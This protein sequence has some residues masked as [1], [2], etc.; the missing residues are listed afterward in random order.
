MRCALFVTVALCSLPTTLAYAQ[1]KLVLPDGT[2]IPVTDTFSSIEIREHTDSRLVILG[3]S[4]RNAMVI[5]VL[6]DVYRRQDFDAAA[7]LR[8]LLSAPMLSL[9]PSDP[10]RGLVVFESGGETVFGQVLWLSREDL[11]GPVHFLLMGESPD[12]ELAESDFR[13][14][15]GQ[16]EINVQ[17]SEL[18]NHPSRLLVA[19][20]L[21][22][23]VA[24]LLFLW[25]AFGR[26]AQVSAFSDDFI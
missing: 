3:H 11:A 18:A 16:M 25:R 2:S 10:N 24:N 26:Y 6:D 4:E 13:R 1:I 9:S 22:L 5:V 21:F 12:F 17:P 14:I 15:V 20:A 19:I 23:L 8:N 7:E